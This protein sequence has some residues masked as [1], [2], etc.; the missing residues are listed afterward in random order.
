[1]GVLDQLSCISKLQT[2]FGCRHDLPVRLLVVET[3]ILGKPIS[4]LI[5][6]DSEFRIFKAGFKYKKMTTHCFH[7]IIEIYRLFLV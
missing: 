2:T 4:I 5:K 1:M 6:E 7:I 3:P